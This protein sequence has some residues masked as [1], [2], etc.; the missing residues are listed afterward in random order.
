[1]ASRHVSATLGLIAAAVAIAFIMMRLL[2]SAA[3]APTPVR[4]L[5]TGPSGV[6]VD[7]LSVVGTQ[8]LLALKG[9]W[10]LVAARAPA[11]SASNNASAASA[12]TAASAS[13]AG[14]PGLQG[15]QGSPGTPGTPAG[16]FTLAPGRP[17]ELAVLLQSPQ[18]LRQSCSVEPRPPGDCQL[19]V[20]LSARV[21]ASSVSSSVSCSFECKAAASAAAP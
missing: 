12:A 7:E 3:P 9:P 21:G 11:A 17:L 2:E 15:L 1:M 4:L 13:E 16:S 10:K 19:Q 14:L 18:A 6:T 8:P 5:N 20:V